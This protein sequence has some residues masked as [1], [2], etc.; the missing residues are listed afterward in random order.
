[1]KRH[2]ACQVFSI[3]VLLATILL[4]KAGETLVVRICKDALISLGKRAI[5]VVDPIS[6]VTL[7]SIRSS[8][9]TSSTLLDVS[10][11]PYIG[12]FDTY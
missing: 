6:T 8:M 7:R 12:L 2:I 5:D 4:L 1:M 9:S 11:R 3:L 10:R